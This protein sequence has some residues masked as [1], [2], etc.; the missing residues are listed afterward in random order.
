[1]SG[2]SLRLIQTGERTERQLTTGDPKRS[3]DIFMADCIERLRALTF[4][5]VSDWPEYP[6]TPPL[7]FEQ[8]S[9]HRV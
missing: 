3:A 2:I 6:G 1:M 5:E 4:A 9:A 7:A 8:E